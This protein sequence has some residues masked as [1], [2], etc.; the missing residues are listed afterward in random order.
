[1]PGPLPYWQAACAG[2]ARANAVVS[3]GRRMTHAVMAIY[4]GA[5]I[6]RTTPDDIAARAA[7]GARLGRAVRTVIRAAEEDPASGPWPGDPWTVENDYYRLR[8]HP[9]G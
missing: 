8:I 4:L 1:M 7:R 2:A 6:S 9:R 5:L 3:G